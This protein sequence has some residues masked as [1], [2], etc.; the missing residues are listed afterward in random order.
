M[1]NVRKNEI[2]AKV[3]KQMYYSN[4]YRR[5]Y[6]QERKFREGLFRALEVLEIEG[7]ITI[8]ET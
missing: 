5:S 3:W 7:I 4:C 1:K 2:A 8:N 6:E